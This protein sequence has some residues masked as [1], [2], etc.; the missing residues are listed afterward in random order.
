MRVRERGWRCVW[1]GLICPGGRAVC[2]DIGCAEALGRP[3]DENGLSGFLEGNMFPKDCLNPR[4]TVV[5]PG[6]DVS[7]YRSIAGLDLKTPGFSWRCCKVVLRKD[8]VRFGRGENSDVC[9][10]LTEGSVLERSSLF[11]A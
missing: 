7:K 10:G 9:S 5:W 3:P 1:A 6:V 8:D 2:C 11:R 4:F